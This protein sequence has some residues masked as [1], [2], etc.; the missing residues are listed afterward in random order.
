MLYFMGID[1][2]LNNTGIGIVGW[3]NRKLH[4]IAHFLVRPQKGSLPERLGELVLGV[5]EASKQ[6]E[7]HSA[8]VE[9]IFY[10]VNAKSALILGQ[11]RG[12]IIAALLMAGV[13]VCEFSA[14]Q[15]KQAVVGY[16]KAEKEQVKKMVELHLNKVFDKI[17]L[18]VTDALACAICLATNQT[19]KVL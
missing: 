10:S 14:L 3:E 15:I 8:A 17:P 18:D 4:Y 13:R 12:A 2:G 5:T 7:I 6:Y 1:P 16:G 19:S 11:A 9:N